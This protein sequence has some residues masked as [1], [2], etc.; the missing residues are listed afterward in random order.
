MEKLFTGRDGYMQV[1]SPA[2]SAALPGP[3]VLTLLKVT[4]FSIQADLELLSSTTLGDNV[5]KY[6][7]GLQSFTGSATVLYYKDA[8]G[9][10]PAI[11]VLSNLIKTGGTGITKSNKV[12]LGFFF[13]YLAPTTTPRKIV[14]DAYITSV[15]IGANV[16]EVVSAQIGFTCD[17]ELSA[18][19]L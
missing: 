12:T 1:A 9:S 18:V 11:T 8:Q 10:N 19:D 2:G 16:G 14:F 5:K 17:G 3:A 15:S 7:P 13:D 4:S 6:V